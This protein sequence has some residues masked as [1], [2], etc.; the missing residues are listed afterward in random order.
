MVVAALLMAT[1]T[2]AHGRGARG[3]AEMGGPPLVALAGTWFEIAAYG[4]WWQPRCV[5]DVSLELEVRAATRAMLHGR[6]RTGS[7]R[8]ERRGVLRADGVDGSWRARFAPRL[9]S[10]LPAVWSDFWVVGYDTG[11]HPGWMVVGERSHTRLSILARWRVLDEAALARALAAAR[12]AGFDIDRLEPTPH[13]PDG[14]RQ[15][16]TPQRSP[17]PVGTAGRRAG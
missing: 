6:C 9:F 2:V 3:Q 12:Q 4:S 13:A 11:E 7:G 16:E 5:Q 17:G 1:V 10:W 15:F 8:D 14:W